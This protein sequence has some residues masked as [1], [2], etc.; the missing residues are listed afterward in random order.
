MSYS[1]TNFN[2]G[3]FTAG[4]VGGASLL[5]GAIVAGVQAAAQAN[6]RGWERWNRRQ[7]ETALALSEAL[8]K[9]QHDDLLAERVENAKLRSALL[10]V[11]VRRV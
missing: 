7:L 10:R 6:A 1:Y 2:A 4:A 5:A 3:S 11:T 8:R 9:L